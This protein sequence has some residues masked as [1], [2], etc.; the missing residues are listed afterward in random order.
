MFGSYFH[1]RMLR[2][3]IQKRFYVNSFKTSISLGKKTALYS[4][5]SEHKHKITTKKFAVIWWKGSVLSIFN[6]EPLILAQKKLLNK[7]LSHKGFIEAL[8]LYTV[9]RLIIIY[10]IVGSW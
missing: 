4:H 2:Y 1:I 9:F 8:R 6:P 10:C 7:P 5:N 3:Y